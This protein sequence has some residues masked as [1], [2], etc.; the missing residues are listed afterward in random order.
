MSGRNGVVAPMAAA[1][2]PTT[3]NRTGAWRFERPVFSDR[4][5]PCSEACPLGQNIPAIMALN[6]RGDF[7]QA[8]Q[9]IRKENPFPGI[10]GKMCFHPCERVCN[11]V[12]FDEAVSIREME[13][14]A[15][16]LAAEK[17]LPE[18]EAQGS[19][20][21]HVGVVGG[22]A[23]GLSCAYFLRLLGHKVTILAPGPHPGILDLPATAAGLG[24]QYLEREVRGILSTGIQLR[25][26]TPKEAGYF[27]RLTNEFQ[28][29]YVSPGEADPED[30]ESIGRPSDRSVYTAE[31]LEKMFKD[32]KPPSL[33]GKV[34]VTGGGSRALKAARRVKELGGEPV[35]LLPF[36]AEEPPLAAREL[37]DA[38]K[39]GIALEWETEAFA[40]IEKDGRIEGLM[41]VK[42]KG[43]GPSGLRGG[44]PESDEAVT[45]EC[46]AGTVIIASPG[47]TGPDI[48]PP[49]VREKGLI[50][51][52][53]SLSLKRG[54]LIKE[55]DPARMLVGRMAQGKQAALS[56]DLGLRKRPFDELRRAAVG[57]LG[58]LSFEVYQ[59]GR[60]RGEH[61]PLNDVVRAKEL[62]WAHFEKASRI[63]P[64]TSDKGFTKR[65]G[66]MSA[67]R[68]FQ[69][70][71]CNSCQK[72]YQYCP[73]LA[74][75]LEPETG[76]PELDYN[77]CK[78]C[79][80]C[81]EECPRG[82]VTL[83][84]E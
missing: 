62:N 5:A 82:A 67:R 6:S 50:V 84:A 58:A 78:G 73:D 51:A 8:Y 32:G 42:S 77:H 52:D 48:I 45:F 49:T 9:E 10:C 25:A 60:S 66:V 53:S 15:F 44:S 3:T 81:F 36:S 70:G 33:K 80:I 30:P 12:Q 38:D 21:C 74:I 28:A 56:L 55:K 54:R 72:C 64:S 40:L 14:L 69:C 83:E 46:E 20:D 37:E 17:D 75:E 1:K 68:C 4:L 57:R 71:R 27:H 18:G 11:R 34:A 59:M 43:G 79:G 61:R 65:Q 35:V 41:C 26:N 29:V 63:K 22:D 39:S 2:L 19:S 23:A 13:Y 16:R 76:R 7:K 31:V 47:S 24:R